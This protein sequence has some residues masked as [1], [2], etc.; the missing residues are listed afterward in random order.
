MCNITLHTRFALIAQARSGNLFMRIQGLLSRCRRVSSNAVS[1]KSGNR[2]KNEVSRSPHEKT[3]G[4]MKIPFKQFFIYFEESTMCFATM[5]SLHQDLVH[6]R[7][8]CAGLEPFCF[9]KKWPSSDLFQKQR[10]F[11]Q[12]LCILIHNKF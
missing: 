6:I 9:W 2:E 1:G 12:E 8:Q 7:V 3:S 5:K 10:G 4:Q 11:I